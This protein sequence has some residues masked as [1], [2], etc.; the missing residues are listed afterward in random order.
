MRCHHHN[1]YLQVAWRFDQDFPIYYPVYSLG[2]MLHDSKRTINSKRTWLQEFQPQ[3]LCS[4][5]SEVMEA[6]HKEGA[7]GIQR[8]KC[9]EKPEGSQNH[10]TDESLPQ[11]SG[12]SVSSN[13]FIKQLLQVQPTGSFP[14]AASLSHRR[15]PCGLTIV[16]TCSGTSS[17]SS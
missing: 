7:A 1:W 8:R 6:K 9:H 14:R 3:T 11:A 4:F 13:W 12:C 2:K 15:G 17:S 10:I 16:I 5:P